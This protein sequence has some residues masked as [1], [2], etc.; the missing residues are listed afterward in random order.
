VRQFDVGK[1]SANSVG[2]RFQC[3]LHQSN[4]DL[5]IKMKFVKLFVKLFLNEFPKIYPSDVEEKNVHDAENGCGEPNGEKGD[6]REGNTPDEG[7]WQS[8]KGRQQTIN[9]ETRAGKE[10]ESRTPN[11]IES[12]SDIRFGQNIFKVQL[13]KKKENQTMRL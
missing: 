6:E 1:A 3:C 4:P 8:Q 11:R 10:D 9:P 13:F 5:S 7:Q 12:M 2:Y